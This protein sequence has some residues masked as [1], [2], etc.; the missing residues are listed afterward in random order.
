MASLIIV[1]LD[2]SSFAEIALPTAFTIARAWNAEIELVTVHEPVSMS[3]VD[4]GYNLWENRSMEWAEEYMAQVVARIKDEVGLDVLSALTVGSAPEALEN[5][6]R[7]R[8]ADLV[9]MTSHG[10]GPLSRIWLGSVT[11]R[12]IRSTSTP[13]LLV[14][15]EE[16]EESDLSKEIAFDRVLIPVDGSQEGDAIL[17]PALALGKACDSE[18]VLLHVSGYTKEFASIYLPHTVQMNA[19][20]M[21]EERKKAE[22]DIDARVE[23]LRSEGVKVTGRVMLDN[24]PSDGVLHFAAQHDIDLIAMATHGR[25]RVA[26]MVLGSVT[27]KVL[28]GAHHPVLVH[29]P[30]EESG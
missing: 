27:D 24:S 4:H 3:D 16:G 28:R 5:H 26:R 22:D 11:D 13:V 23:R 6:V 21:E 25:G 1:P 18:F 10:R 14:R 8:E 29:R 2:G 20:T 9:V 12:F 30:P 17:T 19:E 15:P 7:F